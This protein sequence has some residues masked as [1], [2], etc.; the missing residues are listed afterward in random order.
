MVFDYCL[1]CV[2]G[3]ADEH[4]WECSQLEGWQDRDELS[5]WGKDT[6]EAVMRYL[7][8]LTGDEPQRLAD[9]AALS[10]DCGAWQGVETPNGG[11][12]D[13]QPWDEGE[14]RWRETA[15]DF[16]ARHRQGERVLT[17]GMMAYATYDLARELAYLRGWCPGKKSSPD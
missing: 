1:P 16:L 15:A 8:T 2:A 14:Q 12:T 10:L 6:E 11:W 4:R 9:V 7:A 13:G 5:P 3:C 17:Q